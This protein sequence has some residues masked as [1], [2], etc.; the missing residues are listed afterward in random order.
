MQALM[1]CILTFNGEPVALVAA[2]EDVII[3][4]DLHPRVRNTLRAQEKRARAGMIAPERVRPLEGRV[5]T[6]EVESEG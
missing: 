1:P 3:V 4:S 2:P 5:T 6:K